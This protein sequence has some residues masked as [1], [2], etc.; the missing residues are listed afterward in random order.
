MS[1]LET[2]YD[3]GHGPY[4]AIAA[5]L[6]SLVTL[7][8]SMIIL[9]LTDSTIILLTEFMSYLGN[10]F[11]F[12]NLLF[13]VGMVVSSILFVFYYWFLS[14]YLYENGDE[15]KGKMDSALTFA[16]ITSLGCFMVGI[17][18]QNYAHALHTLGA[19]FTF[20][21][22]VCLT[23]LYGLSELKLPDFNRK[24][25]KLSFVTTSIPFIYLIFYSCSILFGFSPHVTIFFQW[26]SYFALMVWVLV[27][28]VYILRQK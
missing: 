7:S 27:Q 28:A 8:I 12:S 10:G 19:A 18:P 2:I 20:V 23:L 4:F 24:I 5:A 13:N 3:K 22:G 11:R 25:A 6:I 9:T 15:D 16:I 21:G 17:F 26:L 1:I 14:R